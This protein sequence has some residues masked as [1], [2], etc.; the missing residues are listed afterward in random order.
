M[1]KPGG[2]LIVGFINAESPMGKMYEK[3]E[4]K[5]LFIKMQDFTQ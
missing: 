4:M 2:Y 1:L 5:A 3:I